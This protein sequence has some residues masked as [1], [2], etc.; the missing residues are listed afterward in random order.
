MIYFKEEVWCIGYRYQGYTFVRKCVAKNLPRLSEPNL[1]ESAGIARTAYCYGWAAH[2]P[3]PNVQ[4]ALNKIAG[5]RFFCDLDMAN[6]YHQILLAAMTAARL[7]VQTPWG[8]VQPRFL[9]EGVAPASGL[10][11]SIVR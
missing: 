5:F 10:L 7:S 11:Q 2:F 8:Q 9:P 3:I 1:L 6:A 4:Q